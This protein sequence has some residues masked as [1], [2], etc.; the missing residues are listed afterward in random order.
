V[1]K[2]DRASWIIICLVGTL[3]V[4]IWALF[5]RPD[6]VPAW[7]ETIKGVSFSPFRAGQTPQNAS[8]YPSEAQISRDLALLSNKV[9]RVR[10]YSVEGSL[11]SIPKLAAEQGLDVLVGLWISDDIDRNWE[12]IAGLRQII[13]KNPGNIVGI[14]V[15]NEVLLRKEVTREELANYVDIVKNMSGDI[16]VTVAETWD[17]WLKNRSLAKHVDFV[18][19]GVFL[20]LNVKRSFPSQ[21]PSP[22]CPSGV[23]LPA[24]RLPL[25][26]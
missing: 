7:P 9:N 20:T 25:V 23:L 19:A 8:A 5:N 12:E 13:A 6:Y 14:V 2:I 21:H 18:T 16:P 17:I 10:T 11:G 22:Q 4:G 3:L 26:S 15:G 1:L 24:F